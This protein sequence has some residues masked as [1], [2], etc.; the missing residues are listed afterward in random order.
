M[1]HSNQAYQMPEARG[2]KVDLEAFRHGGHSAPFAF[3]EP[4]RDYGVITSRLDVAEA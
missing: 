4:S 2:A 1:F 3:A